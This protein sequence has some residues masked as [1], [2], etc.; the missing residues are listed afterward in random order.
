[1]AMILPIQDTFDKAIPDNYGNAEYRAE[2]ELLLAI[3]DIIS[4]CHLENPVTSYFLDVASVN[5]FISGFGTHKATRLTCGEREMAR[6][7]A[8]LALRISGHFPQWQSIS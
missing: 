6:I 2:R 8:V 3:S 4:Q 7:N 5:K 1:M